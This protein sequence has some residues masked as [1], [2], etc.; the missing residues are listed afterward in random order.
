VSVPQSAPADI[1]E[2][3]QKALAFRNRLDRLKRRTSLGELQWYPYNTLLN[4][5]TLDRLLTGPRRRLLELAASE[6]VLDIGCGDGDLAF[7]MES[8]GCE[9]DAIDF[10]PTNHNAMRGVAELS[11]KLKSAVRVFELDLDSPFTFPRERYGLTFCLGLLYHLRNP[12][13]LLDN[14]AKVT[15]YCLLSTR[16]AQVTPDRR[17]R[18][19]DAPVAYLVDEEETNGDNTNFW[20]FSEAGLRRIL[21]RTGWW[22][23]DYTTTGCA[24]DSDPA[25]PEGDE[26]V[27]CL[28][29]SPAV[30]RDWTVALLEGW[31]QMEDGHFRWTARRFSVR[32]TMA[33]PAPWRMLALSF[34][35]PERHLRALGPVTMQASVNGRALDAQTFA[36]PG[37]QR[38]LAR[39][40]EGLAECGSL[41]IG[42]E[43]DKALGPT[44]QDRRELGVVVSFA[45]PGCATADANL[46]PELS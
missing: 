5:T 36:A 39:L 28:L 1:R 29:R 45:S 12:Y 17:T 18:L 15:R 6:P 4:F 23:L 44:P 32:L 41:E 46:P 27:F 34:H 19:R 2:I 21:K 40:P 13:Y 43:L 22:V 26:R 9:V 35:L 25:T 3:H 38:Y 24:V 33:R 31:H 14:L 16:V 7:F 30:D 11:R 10:P 20:I 42:F 37:D 8:L